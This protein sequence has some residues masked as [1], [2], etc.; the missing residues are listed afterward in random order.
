MRGTLL[1]Y[2]PAGGVTTREVGEPKLELLKEAIGGGYLEVVPHWTSI[3]HGGKRR[4]C[5]A[6]CDEDG[7]RKDLPVNG[8]ATVTWDFAMRRD[9]GCGCAPDYLVGNV[10]VVF[11]DREF[12]EAL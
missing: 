9:K 5:V 6:F 10:V 8:A 12:M 3:E 4:R 7:K 1:I 2:S 11:G